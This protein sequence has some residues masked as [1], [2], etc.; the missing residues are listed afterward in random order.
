M[1]KQQISYPDVLDDDLIYAPSPRQGGGDIPRRRTALAPPRTSQAVGMQGPY[2]RDTD[3]LTVQP[4]RPLRVSRFLPIGIGM[5][6]FFG[7][8]WAYNTYITPTAT[9]L[10]D[11]WHYGDAHTSYLEARVGH[12]EKEHPTQFLATN[13]H[14]R[15][16]VIEIAGG[17]P[18]KARIYTITEISGT[19]RKSASV[20]L[21]VTDINNDG[22]PDLL[23]SVENQPLA[24]TLYND[25]KQF[26]FTLPEKG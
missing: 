24:H 26:I 9:Y 25:G 2:K 18:Q 13:V 11:Q 12:Q 21:K 16:V 7:G 5:W 14:G 1:G 15:I 19:D 22:K 6:I 8:W 17:D 10:Y 3:E 20:T 23:V 4:R